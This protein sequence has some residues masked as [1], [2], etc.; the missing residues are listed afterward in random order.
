MNI[1]VEQGIYARWLEWGTRCGLGGLAIA[2]VVYA[3]ELVDPLVPHAQLPE[4][5]H[6]PAH[7]FAAATGAP[8]GW[9]WTDH[10]DKG[11]YVMLLG[12]ALLGLT[13]AVCYARVIAIFARR[14]ERLHVALAVLQIIVLLAAA[15][16]LLAGGH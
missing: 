6:L 12:V 7:H 3:F 1:P 9:G 13:S 14:G 10:L 2:F 4:L 5:W 8:T 15:S 11:D 16:G